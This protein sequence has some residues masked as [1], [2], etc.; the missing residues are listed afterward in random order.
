MNF[1]RE[2]RYYFVHQG[3]KWLYTHCA[4]ICGWHSFG[5]IDD[6][7]CLE[8]SEAMKNEFDMSM[9]GELSYFLGL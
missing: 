8:F 9:M 1:I 6:S 3:E 5:S 7:M 2:Y 4:N